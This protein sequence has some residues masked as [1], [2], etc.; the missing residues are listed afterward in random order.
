MLT[1]FLETLDMRYINVIYVVLK[2]MWCNL[3]TDIRQKNAR[4]MQSKNPGKSWIDSLI[5]Y[6]A[7]LWYPVGYNSND[8]YKLFRNLIR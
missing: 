7:L 8:S 1:N 6:L 4:T 5:G 3:P 2:D